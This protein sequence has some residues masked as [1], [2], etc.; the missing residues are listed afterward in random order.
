MEIVERSH[1]GEGGEGHSGMV[2]AGLAHGPTSDAGGV[3]R[4]MNFSILPESTSAT[5]FAGNALKISAPASR[6]NA[7]FPYTEPRGGES[8]SIGTLCNKM[9]WAE[10]LSSADA[11]GSSNNTGVIPSPP[12]L[13]T[14][15]WR[16]GRTLHLAVLSMQTRSEF[17]RTG[18]SFFFWSPW[19][20]EFLSWDYGPSLHL[21]ANV[22]VYL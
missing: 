15:R 17:V 21:W 8:L 7:I 16:R 12:C 20:S 2:P 1:Q 11:G 14:G 13:E 22:Q 9:L 18:G 10:S 4:F 19:K 3:D 6:N 5:G